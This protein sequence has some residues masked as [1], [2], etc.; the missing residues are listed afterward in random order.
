MVI[1]DIY[2]DTATFFT[3]QVVT[4]DYWEWV[5]LLNMFLIMLFFAYRKKLMN[6]EKHPEYDYYIWGFYAKIFGSL[7]FAIVYFYYYGGGDTLRYFESAMSMA[8][9]FYKDPGAYFTVLFSPPSEEVRSYFDFFTGFPYQYIFDDPKTYLVVKLV[10]PLVILTAKSY[11]LTTILIGYF[12]YSGIWKLYRLFVRYYPEIKGKL[13]IGIIMLPSCIFWGSGVLKDSFTLLGTCLFTFYV[14]EFFIL[15]N[16]RL[17][18]VFYMLLSGFLVIGIKPYIFML[19]FPGCLLWIFYDKIVE[20][21]K[22]AYAFLFIPLILFGIV[23]FSLLFFSFIGDSLDKFSVDKAM[24]TAAVT[25]NDLKQEYYEG[26]SFDIGNF[27]G[28]PQ[29]AIRLLPMATIA[30]SI[31][32]FIFEADSPFMLLSALENLAITY[33]MLWVIFRGGRKNFAIISSQPLLLFCMIYSF[34]FAYMLGLTTSNFGALVR[35]KI[36]MLPFL[37]SGLF[38]LQYEI[39]KAELKARFSISPRQP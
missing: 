16:Y 15:K 9:L 14:H 36:P 4:I 2:I 13:A 23:A 25:Q 26:K 7:F 8:N 20:F 11:L 33:L 12:T 28:S 21:R 35:F 17:N 30:G 6:V 31:R 5:V 24:E 29:S 27:D 10:S 18:Y 38:I 22:S 3:Q 37:I 19:L 39:R 32:P 34:L 1:L